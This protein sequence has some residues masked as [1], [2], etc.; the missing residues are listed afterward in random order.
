MD[1]RVGELSSLHEEH[2]D[3]QQQHADAHQCYYYQGYFHLLS[4]FLSAN[5]L[6][7]ERNTKQIDLFLLPRRS[8]YY[9]YLL[10]CMPLFDLSEAAA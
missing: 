6:Q 7:V 9:G 5:I 8:V 2:S 3:A 10:V 1:V 4:Q